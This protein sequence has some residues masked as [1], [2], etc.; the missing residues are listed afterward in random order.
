M[1]RSVFFICFLVNTLTFV[2]AKEKLEVVNFSDPEAV[3]NISNKTYLFVDYTN[4]LGIQQILSEDIQSKFLRQSTLSI[5]GPAKNASY[6]FRFSIFNSTDTDAFLEF[7]E[8][9]SGWEIDLYAENQHEPI[10]RQGS[11]LL[12]NT[13]RLSRHFLFR[14]PKTDSVTT[15]YVKMKTAL[16]LNVMPRIGTLD[17]LKASWVP[18]IIIYIAFIGLVV[19]MFLYNL[20]IYI[21][22]RDKIYFYYLGYLLTMGFG[23]PFDSGNPLVYDTFFWEYFFVWHCFFYI[24]ISMF[25]IQYLQLYQNSRKLFYMVVVAWFI[26]SVFLPVTNAF[27]LVEMSILIII[28]QITLFY[29]YITLFYSGWYIW[30]KKRIVNGKFYVLGWGFLIVNVFIYIAAYNGII[31]MGDL[32]QDIIYFGFAGEAT[33]FALALGD[34]LNTLRV[35]KNIMYRQ[36]MELIRSQKKGL[37]VAVEKKTRQ[38][39]ESYDETQKLNAA[40]SQINDDLL[41]SNEELAMKQRQLEKALEN[42]KS[43]QDQLLQSEKYASIGVLASGVA[44]EI[45]NPLNYIQGG[46]HIIED[47]LSRSDCSDKDAEEAIKGVKEGVRKTSEIINALTSYSSAETSMIVKCDIHKIIDDSL[48]VLSGQLNENISITKQYTK[49]SFELQAS[50]TKLQQAIVNV[51]QNSI[52]AIEKTG[53]IHIKTQLRNSTILITIEDSG[54]GIPTENIQKV[55]D[56]FFTTKDPGT[57]TGLGLSMSY[58]FIQDHK[59]S[60]GIKP[61]T[62]RG[63]RVSISLPVLQN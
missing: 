38:L 3:L 14:L 51:I 54:E 26:L 52:Q 56:P 13:D 25:A 16:P 2:F 20:F 50:P 43:T 47:F 37:E 59:G 5:N 49:D 58:K 15:Y 4:D 63:T 40:L 24:F 17:Q 33:L 8:K 39:Q 12:S 41:Q 21:S 61:K 31:N 29:Y 28:F 23:I 60:M 18:N 55:F 57:G 32:T 6:W 30:K 10:E 53:E 34:R 9:F 22:I 1:F 11:L 35:E 42:L 45:N 48:I 7:G 44:H 62:E 27:K 19:G 36:N 46:I